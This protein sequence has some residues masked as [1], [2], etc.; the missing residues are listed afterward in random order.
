[1]KQL[2]ALPA[3]VRGIHRSP[4]D[5]LHK[6]TLMRTFD[7]SLKLAWTNCWT[8]S[9]IADD[10]RRHDIHVTSQFNTLRPR[11]NGRHFADD[12]FKCIFLNEN[13]WIPIKISLKF[14]PKGQ[15]N[16]IPALVQ[17]MAWR[18]PGDKPLSEPMVVNLLSVLPA[19]SIGQRPRGQKCRALISPLLLVW[20]SC[21]QTMALQMIWYKIHVYSCEVTAVI[22]TYVRTTES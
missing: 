9:R 22:Y 21:W 13:V 12:I 5:F 3:F 17:I 1:M 19:L 10:L 8:N 20:S 6:D 7:V 11:Q 4:V 16:K 2:S 14:V 15:I 18:R